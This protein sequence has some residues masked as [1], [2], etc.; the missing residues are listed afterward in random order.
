MKYSKSIISI[1]LISLIIISNA[2]PNLKNEKAKAK[3][4][5]SKAKLG[6]KKFLE[7]PKEY[8]DDLIEKGLIADNL[9]VI[10]FIIICR[11][12]INVT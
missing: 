6:N 9:T 5:N 11:N 2:L 8:Y 10:I 1:L 12:N 4:M 7:K 3:K